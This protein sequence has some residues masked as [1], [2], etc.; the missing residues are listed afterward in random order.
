MLPDAVVANEALNIDVIRQQLATRTI[1]RRIVLHEVVKST[2]ASLRELAEV[3]ALEG[4][5][6]VAESQTAGR[7]GDTRPGSRRPA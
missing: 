7:G 2:N 3:G 4:T 1:G 6:L 5:V